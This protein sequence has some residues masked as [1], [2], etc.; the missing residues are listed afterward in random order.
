MGT[1]VAYKGGGGQGT[2]MW[3]ISLALATYM[4]SGRTAIKGPLCRGI[5]NGSLMVS[6][7]FSFFCLIIPFCESKPLIK[8]C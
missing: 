7:K 4:A 5:D 1:L 2:P 8:F 3:E 6:F